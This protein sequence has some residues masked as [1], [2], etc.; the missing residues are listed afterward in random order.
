MLALSLALAL[1]MKRVALST[2]GVEGMRVIGM[3]NAN[4]GIG[5]NGLAWPVSGGTGFL[6]NIKAACP[7]RQEVVV[8]MELL[9]QKPQFSVSK[10]ACVIGNSN[11]F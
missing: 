4:F 7:R 2:K 8:Q 5:M 1:S 10:T 3:R 11:A 6:H 9:Q